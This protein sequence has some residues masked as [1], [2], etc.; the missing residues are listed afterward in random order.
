VRR[1]VAREEPGVRE[2]RREQEQPANTR[3]RAVAREEPGVREQR[4][5]QEQ[6]ADTVRRAVAR[7]D[8]AVRARESRQWAVARGKKP[9]VMACKWENGKYLF[10]QPCGLWNEP[11][12]HGCRYIHLNFSK[13]FGT[14]ISAASTTQSS[15]PQHPRRKIGNRRHVPSLLNPHSPLRLDLLKAKSLP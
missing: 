6:P 7:L 13:T 11:C 15:S 4:R 5:E 3:Q 1:A 14:G 8:P 9:Y 10:H 12:V 2:Q